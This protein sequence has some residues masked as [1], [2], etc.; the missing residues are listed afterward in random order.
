MAITV[1]LDFGT[2][3]TKICVENSDQPMHKTYEFWQWPNGS[4]A[5]PSVIQ[6]NKDHTVRYGEIDLDDCLKAPKFKHP[7]VPEFQLPPEP[8]P[9]VNTTR[10]LIKPDM[11]VRII[12]NENGTEETIPYGELYG[13][14]K[15]FLPKNNYPIYLSWQIFCD[16]ITMGYSQ[17]HKQWEKIKEAYPEYSYPEPIM[18]ELPDEPHIPGFDYEY[19]PELEATRAEIN[20]YN[21][22][23]NECRHIEKKERA[24]NAEFN[25][26]QLKYQKE[27][28][29]WEERCFHL[30]RNHQRLQEEY[31]A[32]FKEYPMIFR[33]FKQATFSSYRWDYIIPSDM[34][35]VWYLAYVIFQLEK[36]YDNNFA[37]QM[38]IPASQGRFKQAKQY[39]SGLLIRAFR[40][41]ENVFENDFEAFLATPYEKLIE[42]TPDYEYSDD[43][44]EEYGLI[45]L[46]EAYAALRS[47]T[48]NGRI[49]K[50]MS[51]I[52]DMGGG[53][54]DVSF[55]V[56]EE[57]GEP[58][59]YHFH[60]MAKGLNFFLEYS[61]SGKTVDFSK[62]REL[63]DL[64][65]QEFNSALQ[66][67][68]AEVKKILSHV[69]SFL[70]SDTI[71]RGFDKRAFRDAIKDRPLIYTGGGCY[72]ARLRNAEN[73]FTDVKYIDKAMLNIPRVIEE[74][75]ISVPYSILATAFGLS[76]ARDND[77]VLVSP[78]EELFA[79][80]PKKDDCE[81]R[82]NAHREH[83]MYED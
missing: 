58:H 69:T 81:S 52:M 32:S 31:E 14:G 55:F 23:L 1:G 29:A 13:I 67:F 34:L 9:P 25:L 46:P 72:D 44:K 42:L 59:I 77:E 63:E 60:S 6:I 41:V 40:L 21:R 37:T 54:T 16:K 82:W 83:G 45:V 71:S 28:K 75:K 4:F 79:K 26:Q 20:E 17:F 22:W 51:F 56:I 24:R 49:P 47:V 33:Y 38:G 65:P 43:L 57:N 18:P 80:Y 8:Q 7:T 3:Q 74:S 30:E 68:R 11:P 12:R 76:M 39:A 78:M 53:T 50:G 70:H 66:D 36:K 27:H 5:L 73:D 2:H 48:A 15:K 35:S 19:R 61:N 64:S 62:K 10:P